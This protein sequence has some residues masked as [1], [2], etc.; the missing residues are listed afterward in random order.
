MEPGK[1]D[2]SYW[3]REACF[4]GKNFLGKNYKFQ[5]KVVIVA[6]IANASYFLVGLPSTT[7]TLHHIII[8]FK[9]VEL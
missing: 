4:S 5:Q 1:N 9:T 8:L 2:D 3:S 6:R 7:T